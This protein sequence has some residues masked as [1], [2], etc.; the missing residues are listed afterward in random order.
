MSVKQNICLQLS[1]PVK[2]SPDLKSHHV[3]LTYCFEDNCWGVTKSAPAIFL[4]VHVN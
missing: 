3:N 4:Y 1:K 2:C